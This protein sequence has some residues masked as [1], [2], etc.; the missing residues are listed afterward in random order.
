MCHETEPLAG[1]PRP[2]QS[3][4]QAAAQPAPASETPS[5]RKQETL[6]TITQTIIVRGDSSL[7]AVAD[8][9]AAIA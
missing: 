9:L 6:L 4:R 5:P 1:A 7:L 8:A 2:R 3:N